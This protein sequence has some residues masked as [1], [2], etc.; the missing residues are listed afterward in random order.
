M[1]ADDDGERVDDVQ[2]AGEER[3][4]RCFILV[5]DASYPGMVTVGSRR[6]GL[7]DGEGGVGIL[8]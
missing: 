2:G 3:A 8:F 4:E 7:D 5:G 1:K 6:D